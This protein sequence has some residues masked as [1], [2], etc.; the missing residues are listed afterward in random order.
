MD[1]RSIGAGG[2]SIAE[3]DVGGLL[4]VGPASA[5][6]VPGPACYGRG[7]TKPTVTDAAFLL[8]M[9]GHGRLASGIAL[10]AGLAEAAIAPLADALGYT[11]A[12]TAH[13]IMTIAAAGMAS[14]IRSI[15]IERG[16]DPREAVLMPFGGAGPLFATLLA[17]ELEV[18]RIVVPPFAGNF[19]AL[20]VLSAD[21]VQ[22]AA[23]TRILPLEDAS[24]PE[25]N[26]ILGELFAQ[27]SSRAA[28][29][30]EATAE[31]ALDMRYVGQEHSL[32]VPVPGE[33]AIAAGAEEIRQRFLAD[34]E[35]TFDHLIE[36][37]VQIVSLRATLRTRLPGIP[38]GGADAR[39]AANGQGDS[40]TA[41]SFTRGEEMSFAI[42]D[43]A[44]VD[45]AGVD[46]P[47]I[48]V[49]ETATAY[50]DAD[51]RAR[52]DE[53]GVLEIIDTKGA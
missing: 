44:D 29:R 27:L 25:A 19:S 20:G 28:E 50:L 4:T 48:V 26:S 9:L 18:G 39:A 10:D 53:S 23:R 37:Q 24:L 1:V 45:A 38:A 13:G 17:R 7:G 49:E 16:H 40:V 51:F 31:I 42:V 11:V 35:R 6:A 5:G 36:E 30:R 43:R 21:L 2:G 12:E 52:A 34:Y 47:A 22:T 32:T 14:A 15:T 41:W 8:G 33:T 46:G 3:V